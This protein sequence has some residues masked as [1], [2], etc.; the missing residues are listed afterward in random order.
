MYAIKCF[1]KKY[2]NADNWNCIAYSWARFGDFR[3]VNLNSFAEDQLYVTFMMQKRD[4][5][6]KYICESEFNIVGKVDCKIPN[7]SPAVLVSCFARCQS[8]L[9]ADIYKDVFCFFQI[10]VAYATDCDVYF[11]SKVIFCFL[12]Y[13][14]EDKAALRCDILKHLEFLPL[15]II[16]SLIFVVLKW[17]RFVPHIG[18]SLSNHFYSL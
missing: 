10:W 9:H 6:T 14:I 3:E 7:I 18:T 12:N 5:F 15:L 11:C 17:L 8:H 1:L 13:S 16:I 4:W 2:P